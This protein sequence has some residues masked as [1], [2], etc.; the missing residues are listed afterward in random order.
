M[1][2]RNIVKRGVSGGFSPTRW[3]SV[4]SIRENGHFI[5]ELF[6]T[7]FYRKN[8]KDNPLKKKSFD[9]VMQHYNMTEKD[10]EMRMRKSQLL[11]LFCLG[12]GVLVL[13]YMIYLFI[14]DQLLAGFICLMLSF[15]MFSYVFRE[16]F[17]LF[18]MRQ[19][20]LGCTLKEW[21]NSICHKGR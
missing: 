13:G 15:V 18:Q 8:K 5:G 4:E 17:N 2:I 19:R 6:R 21:F 12:L 14:D 7:V 11:I 9:E 16:H 10:L 20:R 1:G 3:M